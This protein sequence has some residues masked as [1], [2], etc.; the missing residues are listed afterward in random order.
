MSKTHFPLGEFVRAKRLSFAS[1][2]LRSKHFIL[3]S[4]ALEQV[5][6]SYKQILDCIAGRQAT[7]EMQT[8]ILLGR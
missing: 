8:I 4:R 3:N 7:D 2:A 1:L 6:L 5:A